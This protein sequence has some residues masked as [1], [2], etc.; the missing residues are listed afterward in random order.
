MSA[1][2]P[3]LDVP[4][5]TVVS[6]LAGGWLWLDEIPAGRD[7]G[8]A[9]AALLGSICRALALPE[10]QVEP[11]FFNYP[12]AAGAALQAGLEG[13]REA[14]FGFV[15]G[16][17]SRAAPERVVLLGLQQQPW[18]DRGCLATCAVTETVSAFAM[19]RAPELKAEAWRALAPLTAASRALG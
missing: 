3:S 18:F 12:V 2:A 6:T 1:A 15:G 8:P 13:A 10:T 14:L 5:F 19:L 4:V 9:Y 16:R 7:P 17:L 11:E